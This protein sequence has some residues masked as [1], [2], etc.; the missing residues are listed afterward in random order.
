MHRWFS[1]RRGPERLAALFP[2]C[3]P[4]GLDEGCQVLITVNPDGSGT[5]AEDTTTGTI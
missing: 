3:P 1:V 4:I 2:Q 5:V